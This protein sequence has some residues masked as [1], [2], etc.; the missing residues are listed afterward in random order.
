MTV[1]KSTVVHPI[2]VGPA[3]VSSSNGFTYSTCQSEGASLRALA[4]ASKANDLMTVGMCTTFCKGYKYAGVEYG[5]EC[6]LYC[7]TRVEISYPG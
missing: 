7:H 3:A 1:Y 5:R 4:L 2:P 6:E